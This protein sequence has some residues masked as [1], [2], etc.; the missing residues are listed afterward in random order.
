MTRQLKQTNIFYMKFEGKNQEY[1]EIIDID[2][3][4]CHILKESK[5]SELSLLWFS[6][7]DNQIKI[8]AVNHTFHTNDI[9]FLTEFH[10]IEIQQIR[11]LKLIRWNRSFYC[12]IDHD[13][14]VSCK[15]LLYYGASVVPNIRPS[16]EELDI[17]ET[18]LKMFRIEM[19]SRDNL[20]MEMLQ[21]MLKRILILCTR[22]YKAQS[23]LTGTET[24]S[25]LIREF[26]FLVEQHFREKHS[27]KAYADLLHKSPKT[28]S[29]VFKKLGKHT[30]LQFIQNRI[31]LEAKRLLT[32]SDHSISEI[33]YD[34][35]FSEIQAFS[36]FFKTREGKSPQYFRGREKLPNP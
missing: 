16:V 4:N 22:I 7:N 19:A 30:P 26:N 15:G 17:L 14:E 33:A 11:S 21:M 13:S 27:V 28:L 8:D 2:S 6:S 12:I 9:V 5:Q 23:Q 35:G 29:N 10:S 34:L 1:I 31:M 24:Q 20:Q 36:R 18:V 25:H 3:S 32:Y